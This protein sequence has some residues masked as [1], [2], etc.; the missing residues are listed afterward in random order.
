MNS[1]Q[2]STLADKIAI[3]E[4]LDEYC[5]RLEL[6]SFEEWLDLFTDDT[7]YEVF[8]QTLQGREEL[9]AMLSQAPDG[10]HIGG[11]ARIEI[12]GDTA[13]T[14]QNYI[15]IGD[16]P[17]HSNQGWYFRTL[18]KTKGSWKIS[19]TKVKLQKTING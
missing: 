10:V 15:F 14:V 8:R 5:L 9:S 2:L 6:N 12:N 13:E 17:Q 19:Y 11:A 3:K 7:T 16:D 1:P 4:V 18:K